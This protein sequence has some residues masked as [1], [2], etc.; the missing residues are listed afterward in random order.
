MLSKSAAR[1]FFILITV[2]FSVIFLGLT[3]DTLRQFPE[4]TNHSKITEVVKLGKH[5]WE[6]K[7]C[8]GCHALMGEGAYYAPDL[9]KSYERRGPV[10][11]KT[12]LK[13]PQAMYPGRRKMV[14]YNFTDE[15]M[16]GVIAFLKWVGEMDLNGFPKKPYLKQETPAPTERISSSGS[17]SIA[18]P[19]IF[20]QICLACHQLGGEG[21]TVGPALDT[22]GQRMSK[23]Q[24]AVWLKDPNAV[25]PGTTMPN[26]GLSSENIELLSAY[27]AVQK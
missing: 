9:T 18:P 4:R 6:D 15:E 14:Q 27:L 20:T 21:G 10:W 23:E 24:L 26:L 11:M 22:V 25:R 16:D 1:R 17:S 7:N 3:I 19:E 13:D 12:F 2:L 8:M 5:I